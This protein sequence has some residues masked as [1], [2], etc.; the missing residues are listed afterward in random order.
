D[1]TAHTSFTTATAGAIGTKD[2]TYADG[3]DDH[4][5]I[6][7]VTDKDG[8][9]NSASFNVHVNNVAPT[10]TLAAGNDQSVNEGST[11]TYTYTISDPGTDTVDHVTTS[12]GDHGTKS[13]AINTN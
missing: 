11:H 2:H 1:G 12:C 6:V 3:P 9:S 8:G 10:V 13:N 4:T 5:V 7:K